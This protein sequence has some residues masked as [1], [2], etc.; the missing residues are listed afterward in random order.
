M[1]LNLD[2]TYLRKG[3]IGE[4]RK[5]YEKFRCVRDPDPLKKILSSFTMVS[6]RPLT[7]LHTLKLDTQLPHKS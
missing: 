6:P 1:Q 5:G 3:P 2:R 7:G 4:L